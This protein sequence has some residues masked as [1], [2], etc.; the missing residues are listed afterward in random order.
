M[1][2]INHF[3]AMLSIASVDDLFDLEQSLLDG[4]S[5]NAP[6]AELKY[7]LWETHLNVLTETER[8]TYAA[9]IAALTAAGHDDEDIDAFLTFMTKLSKVG[10]KLTLSSL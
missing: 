8:K 3:R 1:S 6:D 4:I 2:P 7:S 10:F 9:P 5:A